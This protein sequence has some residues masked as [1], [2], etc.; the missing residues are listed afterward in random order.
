MTHRPPG[1]P[2]RSIIFILIHPPPIAA[3]CPSGSSRCARSLLSPSVW[4]TKSLGK[5][6]GEWAHGGHGQGEGK[7]HC[8]DATHGLGDRIYSLGDRKNGRPN[9]KR[10][11]RTQ[12]GPREGGLRICYCKDNT[13]TAEM[14]IALGG[15]ISEEKYVAEGE[16]SINCCPVMVLT[17]VW[18]QL[19]SPHIATINRTAMILAGYR[20]SAPSSSSSSE[21][22]RSSSG[23]LKASGRRRPFSS[24]RP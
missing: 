3:K 1:G 7:H 12:K 10:P 13:K 17:V 20:A 24:K 9:C 19:T 15:Y 21:R 18:R 5:F 14:Q 11:F 16:F 22:L 4:A 2:R 8:G 23:R 6:N